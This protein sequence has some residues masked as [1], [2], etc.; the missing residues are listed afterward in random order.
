MTLVEIVADRVRV[1]YWD[2]DIP[3]VPTVLRTLGELFE[4]E[5]IEQV[6]AA[7]WGLNGAGNRRFQRRRSS[8]CVRGTHS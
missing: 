2:E 6:Y 3:C 7:C 4:L 5:V 8:G 1:A